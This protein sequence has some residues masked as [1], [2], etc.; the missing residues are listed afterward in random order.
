MP[1][2]TVDVSPPLPPAKKPKLYD[3]FFGDLF[4]E[5]PA[6]P[7]NTDEVDAYLASS[8]KC[9]DVLDYWKLQ[10]LTWP[11]LAEVAKSVLCIPATETSSERVFSIA[12]CTLDDRRTQLSDD[13][14]DD[15]LFIHGLH[16]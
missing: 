11:H 10:S 7:I 6:V 8:Q 1:P 9:L 13:N 3:S 14:I 5:V 16:K 4:S 12:G 2:V 15:L